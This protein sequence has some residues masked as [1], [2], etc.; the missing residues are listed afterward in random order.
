MQIYFSVNGLKT[1]RW[2]ITRLKSESTL[3]HFMNIQLPNYKNKF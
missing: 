3:T 2:I 1:D